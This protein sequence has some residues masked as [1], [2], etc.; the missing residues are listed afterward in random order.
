LVAGVTGNSIVVSYPD[1]V[2]DPFTISGS[3]LSSGEAS[4]RTQLM[5][6]ISAIATGDLKDRMAVI[7]TRAIA[8]AAI[9]FILTRQ[10]QME[11][12]KQGGDLAGLIVGA[13][14]S[15]L[16]AAT[17]TADTRGWSTLPAQIRMARLR[18]PPGR[19]DLTVRFIDAGGGAAGSRVFAGVEVRKGQRT[20][21]A[22]RTAS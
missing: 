15:A 13:A 3:E 22:C 12:Q 4:A 17:E 19:H 2:Q 10:A 5:E 11:A 8:R 14:T 21:I 1:Y 18:L 9:K 20:Y 6:D 16:A 7:R